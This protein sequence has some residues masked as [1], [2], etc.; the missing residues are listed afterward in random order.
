LLNGKQPASPIS[1]ARVRDMLPE[2]LRTETVVSMRDGVAGLSDTPANVSV[3]L[4]LLEIHVREA[5]A[6]ATD[7]E[8][9]AASKVSRSSFASK[10]PKVLRVDY[11]IQVPRAVQPLGPLKVLDARKRGF[12]QVRPSQIG[13][14]E[15]GTRQIRMRQISSQQAGA[16]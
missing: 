9:S 2:I 11:P 10:Q 16:R 14:R 8:G 6:A 3:I 4:E 13:P 7:R 12:I 1:I 15:F 5:I